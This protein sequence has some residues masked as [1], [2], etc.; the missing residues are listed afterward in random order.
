[1][2]AGITI[3]VLISITVIG[4]ATWYR[5]SSAKNKAVSSLTSIESSHSSS[6]ATG[7]DAYNL[8]VTTNPTTDPQTLTKNVTQGIFSDFVDLSATG[9][10]TDN[11]LDKLGKVYADKIGS[12]STIKTVAVISDLSVVDDSDSSL[13]KY[14][15]ALSSTYSKYADMAQQA[16]SL[17][18]SI[19]STDKNFTKLM[20]SLADI[21]NKEA[22]ELK[23]I[24]VPSS[25]SEA[26]LTLINNYYNYS[27]TT[28]ALAGVNSDP[29]MAYG[30]MQ[31]ISGNEDGAILGM[32][33]E[34]LAMHNITLQLSI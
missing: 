15:A 1:M 9:Q 27:N 4:G 17:S 31:S 33:S 13:M 28:K 20:L 26:H 19:S 25:I 8:S 34:I 14:S 2:K 7:A 18:G 30:A 16:V 10:A 5:I 22:N 3:A 11:N 6:D 21:F 29:L 32:I 12:L 24:P 23:K